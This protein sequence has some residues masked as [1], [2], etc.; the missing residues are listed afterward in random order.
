MPLRDPRQG[1]PV[2]FH[3]YPATSDEGTLGDPETILWSSIR[4]LCSRGVA[5]GVGARIHGIKQKAALKAVAHNLDLYIQQAFEF[6][7][8]ARAAKPNTAPL[9]YYYSFLNLAKAFCELRRPRFHERPECYRHGLSW[10]PS[11]KYLVDLQRE[12]VS[13]TSRGVWHA[14]WESLR[15]TACPAANPTR[16]KIKLLDLV[17][18]DIAYDEAAR[19]A[20]IRFSVNRLELKFYG[21]SAAALTDSIRTARSGFLEVRSPKRELRTFESAVPARLRRGQTILQSLRDD[22]LGMNVF[23]HLGRGNQLEYCIPLQSRLP[24]RMPQVMVLYTILFWLGSLV[25]YDP[26]SVAELME[27]PYWILLDG[28]MTQSRLWLLEQFEWAFYQAETTLWFV[29]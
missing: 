7:E 9:I 25:R 27:S 12:E 24:V 19:E 29:R 5:E 21:L 26:H 14:L 13:L 23:S 8:A 2:G 1:K 11:P 20:W 28:F 4:H 10:R 16:I 3:V 22:V 18:P 15:Q 17:E 6:Y